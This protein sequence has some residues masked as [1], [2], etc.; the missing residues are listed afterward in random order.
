MTAHAETCN[1]AARHVA[2]AC[3]QLRPKEDTRHKFALPHRAKHDTISQ[4]LAYSG[5]LLQMA[6]RRCRKHQVR[7]DCACRDVQ[8][9]SATCCVRLWTTPLDEDT[10]H[11]F[12]LP[13]RPKHE[14]ISQAL[15]YSGNLLQMRGRRCSKDQVRFDCARRDVQRCSATCCVR[16]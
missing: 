9:C 7:F 10:R 5:Y 6:G 13:H 3:K 12:A 11:G 1:A 4:A 15:A 2:Y 14:T 16:L 8:R